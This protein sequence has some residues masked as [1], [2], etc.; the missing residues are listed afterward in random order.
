MG[1]KW[2]EILKE[3]AIRH[4]SRIFVQSRHAPGG[5]LYFL[6]SFEA[7]AWSF[8]AEAITTPVEDMGSKLQNIQGSIQ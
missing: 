7:A 4:A 1:G 5:G 2:V 3:L 6:R 8:D